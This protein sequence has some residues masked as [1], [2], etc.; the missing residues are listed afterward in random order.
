MT[1]IITLKTKGR[2]KK[3]PKEASPSRTKEGRELV[4]LV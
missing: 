2:A 4:P 3:G 1:G